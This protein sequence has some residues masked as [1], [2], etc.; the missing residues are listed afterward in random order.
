[1]PGMQTRPHEA[2]L[3]PRRSGWVRV[4]PAIAAA[5]SC[6]ALSISSPA[7]T[8]AASTGFVTANGTHLA[9][10]GK[11]WYFTGY[12]VYRLPSLTVG[13]QFNCGGLFGTNWL[14]QILDEMKASSGA[15]VVRTWFFQ[16]Y[17]GANYAQ[18]DAVLAAAAARG[19]KVVPVLVNQW[20]ECEPAPQGNYRNLAW[21][22]GGYKLTNDGYPLSFRSYAVA[23]AA[24]YA[25]NPS[26]AF[27]QLVNEAEAMNSASGPC[28][29]VTA[30][31]AIR[32]FADDV[33]TV[34]KA[35]DHNHLIS[36]GTI[37]S[38][39][40]GASGPWY[41]YVHSGSVDLCE[42][43]DYTL[44]A[45]SGDPWNGIPTDLTACAALGKPTFAGEVGVDAGLQPDG[46]AGAVTG[47][48]LTR[49]AALF[50]AKLHAQF[51]AGAVGF[52]IWE[53]S[54]GTSTGYEV[55]TPDPAE[56][57]MASEARALLG[58]SS[59]APSAPPASS[60]L[61]PGAGHEPNS[62]PAGLPG[63][64]PPGN[65]DALNPAQEVRS[66]APGRIYF[67]PHYR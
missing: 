48:S 42:Y 18:F 3:G 33:S 66:T 53:K 13:N 31:N 7:L 15:T 59:A 65:S 14:D 28:D 58:S 54:L 8:S 35:V 12:D 24:H 57:V 67:G 41:K 34:M 16:S 5:T 43:H 26:I 21:Y 56:A 9:V 25:A 62:S 11:P 49:R 38:G 1:M 36:L 17:S 30:A 37:G 45:L 39:Q 4:W 40:C 50:Q 46:S 63:Q 19:I 51:Q 29:G 44:G 61:A 10:N 32:A 47:S 22:Q 52:L 23:M 55:G 2:R 60:G 27:W 64:R 20:A 6:V